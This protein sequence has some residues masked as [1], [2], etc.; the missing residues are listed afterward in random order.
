MTVGWTISP[1][2]RTVGLS[3]AVDVFH[4]Q[5]IFST[6]QLLQCLNSDGKPDRVLRFLFH[7]SCPTNSIILILQSENEFLS[8]FEDYCKE[9][10][11]PVSTT[12]VDGPCW[13]PVNSASG[14]ARPSTRPVLTGVE[15][16]WQ[17]ADTLTFDLGHTFQRRGGAFLR[18]QSSS[19]NAVQ[20]LQYDVDNDD[21]CQSAGICQSYVLRKDEIHI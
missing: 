19:V 6:A 14:N 15:E 2:N 5:D 3:R 18:I 1:H 16:R 17:F 8:L 20:Y 13:R 11:S 4:K 7:T 21:R 9:L 12:R 10:L